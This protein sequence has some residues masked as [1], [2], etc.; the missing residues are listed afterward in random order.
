MKIG[1]KSV[2]F[3]AH[4]WFIHPFFVAAA[5][6]K[7]YGFPTDPRLWVAF[8][9]HDLGYIGKPNIDGD[10]GETHVELGAKIMSLFDRRAEVHFHSGYIIQ[11]RRRDWYDLC[12]Y[13]SRFYAKKAGVEVSKLCAADKLAVVL[14]PYWL[15]M[16]RVWLSGE[17]KEF[18][19]NAL[20]KYG[21]ERFEVATPKVWFITLRRHLV[22]WLRSEGFNV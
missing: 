18:M 15:Y 22:A 5:W 8:F 12:L 2:L 19:T 4:C 3:G 21:V 13:H 20:T 11:A 9:V 14:E 16:P 6:S 7:L 1:T 10:E 17:L